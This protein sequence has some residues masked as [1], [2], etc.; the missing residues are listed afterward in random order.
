MARATRLEYL[1]SQ[2][3]VLLHYLKLSVFPKNL[4]LDYSWPIATDPVEIFGK[5]LVILVILG[6]G[7]YLLRKN[8]PVGFLIV[9]FFIILAP[10]ST[11]KPLLLAF[12]HRMYL[13]LACVTTGIACALT[14]LIEWCIRE[15]SLDG[16]ATSLDIDSRPNQTITRISLII[17]V[18]YGMVLGLVTYQRNHVYRSEQAVW[19]DVIATRPT[20]A[21]AWHNLGVA[22]MEETG[23]IAAGLQAIEKA[24]ELS[25]EYGFAWRQLALVNHK[26]GR[27]QDA[28][29]QYKTYRR[30]VPSSQTE[31]IPE[32]SEAFL[33]AREFDEAVTEYQKIIDSSA[34]VQV[35]V[36]CLQKQALA[37]ALLND[38][39][40]A[41][42]CLN[43]AMEA[44]N[45][46]EQ[47]LAA[48]GTACSNLQKSTLTRAMLGEA[49]KRMTQNPMLPYLAAQL[50]LALNELDQAEALL[51]EAV[52]RDST[53]TPASQQLA[54]LHSENGKESTGTTER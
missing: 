11:I 26:T 50:E 36:I 14:V 47:V 9:A 39:D 8:P 54:T 30:L 46:D 45:G 34:P 18:A 4:C 2:P 21:R 3:G 41:E 22:I 33:Y 42:R 13:P 37:Y 38:M 43:E 5:G 40:N 49:S 23:N 28:A 27:F 52:R 16:N 6:T 20:N 12:E 15:R 7:F 25:P 48:F 17:L 31:I 29:A 53:F 19:S 10:T 32:V 35:K 44:S 51:Q 24:I 1:C